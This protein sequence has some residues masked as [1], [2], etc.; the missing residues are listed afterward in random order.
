M[1]ILFWVRA[2]FSQPTEQNGRQTLHS[3]R[4]I[5][6]MSTTQLST[7]TDGLCG[8]ETVG[9]NVQH[10]DLFLVLKK[11]LGTGKWYI[12]VITSYSFL[13]LLFL[14]H[15]IGFKRVPCVCIKRV[16]C[17]KL[18]RLAVIDDIIIIPWS[19]YMGCLLFCFVLL[20]SV[21]SLSW[22]CCIRVYGDIVGSRK[23]LLGLSSSLSLRALL[24]EGLV[25]FQF[26]K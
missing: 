16:D 24:C 9:C 25:L 2:F 13:L 8:G 3:L 20:F 7:A 26:S 15:D 10:P 22:C 14:N 5:L 21:V 23:S 19:I 6:K 18:D 12:A 4:A 17:E 1:T 11:F